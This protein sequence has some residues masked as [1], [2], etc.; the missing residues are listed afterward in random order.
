[1]TMPKP[2]C[3]ILLVDDNKDAAEMLGLLLSD[4][5]YEIQ[6]AATAEEAMELAKS[7]EF[8]LYVLDKRLP[9]GSGLD[10]CR[11]LT[12]LTPAV[13]CI[14]YSAD[15][16]ETHRQ[17]AIRAGADSYVT[18]PNIEDLIDTVNRFLADRECAAQVPGLLSQQRSN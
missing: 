8:D 2:K 3:L 18:K 10:L 16:Y 5:D 14:F 7:R 11:Q 15:A 9:D 13:P 12:A 6:T 17:E 1:M 4:W